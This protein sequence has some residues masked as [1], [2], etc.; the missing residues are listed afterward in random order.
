MHEFN[1]HDIVLTQGDTLLF[2]IL[3]NGRELPEG[4]VGY[5]TVK[6]NPR[7]AEALIEKKMDA[8]NEELIVQL[9]S[10]DTNLPARTYYW[11][12][13]VLIPRDE[14]GYEVETPMEYAAFTVLEAVGEAGEA[15]DG[16]DRDLPVLSDLVAQTRSLIAEVEQKLTD[17]DF[18]GPQGPQG[19]RGPAGRIT[20]V[21]ATVDNGVGQPG[22]NVGYGGTPEALELYLDFEN[23]KGNPGASPTMIS[24]DLLDNEGN[25]VGKSLVFNAAGETSTIDIYNGERGPAGKITKVT[26]SVVG[27]TGAPGVNVGYGG[28]PEELELYLDFKNIQ[29]KDGRSV[30][31]SLGMG[32]ENGQ[33]YNEVTFTSASGTDRLTIYD[34]KTPVRGTDYW[35][36][37]DIEAI[38]A[39][40]KAY[41][42]SLMG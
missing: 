20:R 38:K 27:G 3:L 40:L 13:R 29:G 8:S 32:V 21:T 30:T 26:A 33:R 34:G 14:G 1:G 22:V 28:T 24:G 2:K 9:D 41:V 10:T 7:L 23:L 37:A 19:E 4:S 36:A 42:D 12:V 31:H 17:G 6:R 35:T 39:E 5:F 11:D 18:L 25:V 15:G 16:V